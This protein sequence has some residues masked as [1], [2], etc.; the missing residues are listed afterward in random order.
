MTFICSN[1]SLCVGLA[2]IASSLEQRISIIQFTKGLFP[3]PFSPFFP[4]FLSSFSHFTFPPCFWFLF[5]EHVC[6]C[7]CMYVQMHLCMHVRV[8]QQPWYHLPQLLCYCYEGH[9]DQGNVY[10]EVFNWE[11]AYGFR[12]V[13]DHHGR[14]YIAAAAA[15]GS[16]AWRW[17]SNWKLMSARQAWGRSRGGGEVEGKGGKR[18]GGERKEGGCQTRHESLKT[19]SPP[20]PIRLHLLIFPP[21]RIHMGSYEGHSHLKYHTTSCWFVWVLWAE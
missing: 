8:R 18:G 10:N 20:F 7:I 15:A 3:F 16:T 4:P 6:M 19:Q 14:E 21:N 5:Y 9:H 17:S 12:W 11:L 13:Y 2:R 1:N